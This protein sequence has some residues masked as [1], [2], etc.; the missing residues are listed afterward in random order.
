MYGILSALFVLEYLQEMEQYEECQKIIDAIQEQNRRLECN[1]PTHREE[2]KI[3]DV[4][5]VYKKTGLMGINHFEN[6]KYYSEL[7]INEIYVKRKRDYR[8]CELNKK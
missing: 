4:V 1:L 2:L 8:L 5:S 7:I 6:S 3:K